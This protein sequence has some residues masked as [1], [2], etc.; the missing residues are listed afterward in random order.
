MAITKVENLINPE[1]MGQYLDIK[2]I[3]AIKLSPLMDVNTELQGK[4]GDTLTLPKY[5][6]IGDADDVAEGEALVPVVLSSTST[7]I[8]VK[9]AGKAVEITDESVLSGYGNPVSEAGDQLLT[10]V[11]AKIEKD[12]FVSL[13]TATLK[14]NEA[15]AFGKETI[16]D[17]L[18]KFGEDIDEEM[19]LYVNATQYASLRK[20]PDFVKIQNGEKLVSGHVGTIYGC[21]VVVS[22]RVEEKEAFIVKRKA[23]GLLLKRNVMVESDRDILKKT[24][25]IA[26]DEHFVT[27]L[28]DESRAIKITM[29]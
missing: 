14:H 19:F 15:T 20:D 10:S 2:L 28:R 22:N 3:D 4:P 23:L 27:Y 13:R 29:A 6:Y 11:A 24:N 9:K 16:V 12:A 8:K 25:V 1:V 7:G 26:A 18:V 17:A 21:E 5:A